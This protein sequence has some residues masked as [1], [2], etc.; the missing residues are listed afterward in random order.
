VLLLHLLCVLLLHLWRWHVLLLWWLW[1][2]RGRWGIR[3]PIVWVPRHVVLWPG[4]LVY[5]GAGAW[6]SAGTLISALLL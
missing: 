2:P 6:A 1:W 4:A 3:V 5:A